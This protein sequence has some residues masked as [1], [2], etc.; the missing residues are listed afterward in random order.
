MKTEPVPHGTGNSA[1][2]D[3]LKAHTY[4]KKNAMNPLTPAFIA[5]C[6]LFLVASLANAIDPNA[7]YEP[8]DK[9][10]VAT[11]NDNLGLQGSFVSTD[12]RFPKNDILAPALRQTNP[13]TAVTAWRGERV[14][15]QIALWST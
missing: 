9:P 10:P 12:L 6:A 1:L 5:V 7:F 15:V 14:N 3:L 4:S 13:T 8:P 11:A 2:S